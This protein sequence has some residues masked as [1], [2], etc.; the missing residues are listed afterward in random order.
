MMGIRVVV[1]RSLRGDRLVAD[2]DDATGRRPNQ[3]TAPSEE[4]EEKKKKKRPSSEP[5]TT[6]AEDERRSNG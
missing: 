2:F 6:S 1:L 5:T 3:N 4:E